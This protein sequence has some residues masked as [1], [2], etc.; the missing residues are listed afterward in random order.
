MADPSRSPAQ[1]AGLAPWKE[2]GYAPAIRMRTIFEMPSGDGVPAAVA[3]RKQYYE[4]TDRGVEKRIAERLAEI[5]KLK[6]TKR[7]E[8]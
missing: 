7:E 1:C 5:R 4:P 3:L 6:E 8:S 2:W